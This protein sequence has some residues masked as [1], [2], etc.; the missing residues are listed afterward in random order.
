M[1][2][3]G[4][5]TTRVREKYTSHACLECQRRKR[6]CSGGKVC[7]NCRHWGTDCTFSE[8]RRGAR[9]L[10]PLESLPNVATTDWAH[11]DNR[12]NAGPSVSLPPTRDRTPVEELVNTSRAVVENV[13][14]AQGGLAR[15]TAA[16]TTTAA[17]TPPPAPL[18]QTL[19]QILSSG[20]IAHSGD[21][22]PGQTPV[23]TV[24]TDHSSQRES[25]FERDTSFMTGTSFFQQ[26]DLL[27]RSVTQ[28]RGAE[29][30]T[31]GDS[32]GNLAVEFNTS[33]ADVYRDIDATVEQSRREDAGKIHRSLDI[34]FANV[35][36]HYP[37]MNEGHMRTRFSAYVANDPNILTKSNTVQLAALL[38]FIMA[39][40]SI[41]CD[42]SAEGEPLPGWKDFCRGEKLLSHTTWLE[43]ANIVTIQTLL[44]KTLYFMY[45][46]LLNSAYDT[47]GTTVRLCFQL[48]LHNESSWEENCKFY[49][50][51]YRQRVFW[52]VFCLNHNVAQTRGVPELLRESDLN[53]GLPKCVDDR[54]L[55]PDC[56]LLP[57]MPTTSPVPYLLETIK[58]MKISSQVW[59]TIFGAQA[60]KPVS[61]DI[62]AALDAKAVELMR[63][64]PGFL[65]WP[66]IPLTHQI[67]EGAPPFIQQQGFILH[68]RIL[69]LRML[70]RREEMISLTSG[71]RAAQFCIDI[72]TEIIDAVETFRLSRRNSRCERHAFLHHLTGALIPMIYIIAKQ[73]GEEA[74]ISKATTLMNKSLEIIESFAEGS[75]L[76]RRILQHLQRAIKVA[77][78]T[79]ESHLPQNVRPNAVSITMDLSTGATQNAPRSGGGNINSRNEWSHS[80]PNLYQDPFQ[81]LLQKP[82]DIALLW[83]H[84][85]ID[86]WNNYNWSV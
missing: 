10:R 22:N 13:G 18:Q 17:T 31:V 41:L 81:D 11:V 46:G 62:I 23:S 45:A 72:A 9:P 55:Y 21:S 64:L 29:F 25:V 85:S 44:V 65:R 47:M 4:S 57:E 12:A 36:P 86:L 20:N 6:K 37:C 42:T 14:D 3:S 70:L 73:N 15:P 82:S 2:A 56:P 27:D 66:P 49:D 8:S 74:L 68:L 28:A 71:R 75:F 48:S 80:L 39:V 7:R 76:A 38:N 67:Y 34:F 84:T 16:A 33:M 52:S 78:D 32:A 63:N 83:D 59:E 51:T 54:M 69:Y 79:I 5:G 53:I 58:L 77:R 60:K 35:Q 19:A 30:T 40:V 24:D 50:R 1:A 61:Q 43:K 26:I